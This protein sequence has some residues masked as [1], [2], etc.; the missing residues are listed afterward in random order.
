ME[1]FIKLFCVALVFIFV[2]CGCEISEKDDISQI[3]GEDTSKH[4]SIDDEI[5]SKLEIDTSSVYDYSSKYFVN[6]LNDEM[7]LYFVGI[8]EQAI[9]FGD[10][11]NFDKPVDSEILDDVM[12]L[13]NYDCPELIQL[14]GEYQPL[15]C[16]EQMKTVSGVR[17]MYNMSKDDYDERMSELESFFDELKITLEGK[18]DLEKEK[19]I[20]AYIFENCIYDE[21]YSLSGSAYGTL[22]DNRGRCEGFCK[23]FMWCMRELGNN[24]I[25]V[26]GVPKWD[27]NALYSLHS[28]NIVEIDGNYYHLDITADKVHREHEPVYPP[29]YGLFNVD[30][31]TVLESRTINELYSYLGL[32]LCDSDDMN[33]HKMNSL[34]VSESAEYKT[35]FV[36]ILKRNVRDNELDGISVRFESEEAY[37]D[38]SDNIDSILDEMLSDYDGEYKYTT[39]ANSLSRTLTIC[40]KIKEE[41]EGEA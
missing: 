34:V 3:S 29:C 27:S 26:S 6:R 28:W 31:Q 33:Y 16:D 18:S 12:F 30:D 39:Y 22:I 41:S 19:Y 15:Y 9:S 13:V 5:I 10:T 1:S 11:V 24:C 4:T 20:Y 37:D 40:A 8:Y 25:C 35:E 36:D 32:P 7:L 21:A 38:V 2:F 23:S 17:L 14:L